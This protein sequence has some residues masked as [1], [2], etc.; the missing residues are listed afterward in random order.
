[1]TKTPKGVVTSLLACAVLGGRVADADEQ[2][3]LQRVSLST[4]DH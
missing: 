3:Q 1:M 2:D 4:R